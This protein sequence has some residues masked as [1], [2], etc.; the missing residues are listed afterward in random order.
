MESGTN[1]CGN[2]DVIIYNMW[3]DE[4]WLLGCSDGRSYLE[5]AL[6]KGSRIIP[7]NKRG[8]ESMDD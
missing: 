5:R 8:M 3:L 4:A 2:C 6:M 7:G 1:A